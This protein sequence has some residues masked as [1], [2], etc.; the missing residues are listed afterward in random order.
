L[1]F[2]YLSPTLS[3]AL[4]VVYGDVHILAAN[5]VPVKDDKNMMMYFV[6]D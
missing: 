3:S 6:Y 5:F 1:I 4:Y 2:L